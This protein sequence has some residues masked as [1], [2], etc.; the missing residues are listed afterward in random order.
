[1]FRRH[2]IL[3]P[4]IVTLENLIIEN[5]IDEL[6]KIEELVVLVK[7]SEDTDAILDIRKL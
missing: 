2:T 3:I 1:M 6:K 4:L 5:K 7:S